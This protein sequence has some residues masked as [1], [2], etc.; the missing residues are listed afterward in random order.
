M[1]QT[2]P[3]L[4]VDPRG[5]VDTAS[6]ALGQQNALQPSRVCSL[7]S[8]YSAL[9]AHFRMRLL[10]KDAKCQKTQGRS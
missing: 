4:S 2:E 7:L 9:N 5:T 10:V 1:W 3:L 8:G 6:A